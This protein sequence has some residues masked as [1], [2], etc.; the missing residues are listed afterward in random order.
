MPR[1][2]RC[3][4]MAH[5]SF[6]VC[7]SDCVG[8]CGNVCLYQLSDYCVYVYCVVSFAHIKCYSDCSCR[9]SHLVEPFCYVVI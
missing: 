2:N 9:G 7:C 5:V 4:Y 6:Y 8:V 1:E 3:M